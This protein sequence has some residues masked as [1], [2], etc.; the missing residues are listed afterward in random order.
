MQGRVTEKSFGQQKSE[1]KNIP[2]LKGDLAAT[3]YWS[4]NFLVLGNAYS[5]GFL[6]N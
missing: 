6:Y 2:R 3:L 5:P 4:I 1:K